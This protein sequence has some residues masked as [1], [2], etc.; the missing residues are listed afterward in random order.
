M[1]MKK[2]IVF[3]I[4]LFTFNSFFSQG[5][6]ELVQ[7]IKKNIK[8][9]SVNDSLTKLIISIKNDQKELTAKL[10]DEKKSLE[11]ERKSLEDLKKENKKLKDDLANIKKIS[12][13][14]TEYTNAIA[15]KDQVIDGLK[16]EFKELEEQLKRENKKLADNN[17]STLS[18][19]SEMNGTFFE[20]KIRDN[21][22]LDYIKNHPFKREDS[23]TFKKYD[24][25]IISLN[26]DPSM[27]ELK[28][29]KILEKAAIYNDYYFNLLDVYATLDFEYDS[30]K[31]AKSLLKM[32]SMNIPAEFEG[33]L[34]SKIEINQR[35][36][37]YCKIQADLFKN[38]KTTDKIQDKNQ[39][40]NKI[41]SV[42][43]L[44][45][46]KNY[47]YLSETILQYAN[48]KFDLPETIC[49]SK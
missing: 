42:S 21:Y 13:S 25:M 28:S 46:F 8:I 15:K 9:E 48:E 40:F 20:K 27:E 6:S 26:A 43:K 31:V 22:T 32:N 18:I 12:Y 16:I 11:D 5:D 3:F 23:L 10:E 33:L 30:V 38:L 1:V 41:V 7:Y 36:T 14:K 19:L 44:D 2:I 39:R 4:F 47:K 49:S 29:S 34:I 24:A 35:L 17:K 45:K 37:E